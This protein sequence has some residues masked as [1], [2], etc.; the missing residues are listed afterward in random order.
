MKAVF[1]CLYPERGMLLITKECWISQDSIRLSASVV[2]R[3]ALSRQCSGPGID[4]RE[5]QAP[6]KLIPKLLFS[7]KPSFSPKNPSLESCFGSNVFHMGLQI[8]RKRKGNREESESPSPIPFMGEAPDYT[9]R[10]LHLRVLLLMLSQL[11]SLGWRS[12]QAAHCL[13]LG[14]S[15]TGSGIS[16]VSQQHPALLLI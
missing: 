9:L 10:L 11:S 7:P 15:A 16:Q 4:K 3:S 2:E 1:I 12:P 5:I 6:L 14:V 13:S 8:E